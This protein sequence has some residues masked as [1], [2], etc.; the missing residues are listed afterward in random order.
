MPRKPR[1]TVGDQLKGGYRSWRNGTGMSPFAN[2]AQAKQVMYERI[3]REE[4]LARQMG[5]V[6]LPD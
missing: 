5:R 1:P 2:H 4:Q 6:A 3:K